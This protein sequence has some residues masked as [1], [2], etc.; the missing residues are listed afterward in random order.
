MNDPKDGRGQKMDCHFCVLASFFC[1]FILFFIFFFH[2]VS[3]K[4]KHC[5]FSFVC[6]CVCVCV[7]EASF[8]F[9]LLHVS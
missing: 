3:L 8:N 9:F 7:C 2:L 6:V 1:L 4:Y 5:C